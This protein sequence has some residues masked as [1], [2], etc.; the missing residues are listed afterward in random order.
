MGND[1]DGLSADELAGL[2]GRL[3]RGLGAIYEERYRGLVLYGSYA[4]GEADGGSD[5]DVLLLL[6]GKVEFRR[7]EPV[8]WPLSLEMVITI[9]LLSV[10]VERYRSGADPFM[11]NVRKEG[12][13]AA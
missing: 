10:S 5:V 12:I 13:R 2:M 1:G 8:T 6:D 3:S 4:R 11:R 7:A 9:S